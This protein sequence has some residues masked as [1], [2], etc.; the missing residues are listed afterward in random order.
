MTSCG[1]RRR[2]LLPPGERMEAEGSSRTWLGG[3]AC[4]GGVEGL[5]ASRSLQPVWVRQ[6]L[7]YGSHAA[8]VATSQKEISSGAEF[9]L[10]S[11]KILKA[12][13]RKNVVHYCFAESKLT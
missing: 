8:A 9:F 3:T 11:Q 5:A 1:A 7:A 2:V 13:S 12:N 4:M 10:R 6:C